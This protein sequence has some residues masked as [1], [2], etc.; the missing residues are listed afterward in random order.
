MW[1]FDF[2]EADRYFATICHE[3]PLPEQRPIHVQEARIKKIGQF[4][5][6]HGHA[7]KWISLGAESNGVQ[8]LFD[9]ICR[10]AWSIQLLDG[11]LQDLGRLAVSG[12]LKHQH[13]SFAKPC[14]V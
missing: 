11:S 8:H 3:K 1:R 6:M 9:K 2:S 5:H 12:F 13:D 14:R 7:R 4:R 10:A